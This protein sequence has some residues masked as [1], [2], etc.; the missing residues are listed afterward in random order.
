MLS[1]VI[2]GSGYRAEYF[3]R[4][5]AAYPSLFRAMYLCRSEEKAALMTAHTG[6]P[7]STSRKEC[8]AFQ[9][10]FA[11]IAVDR[12]H[13]AEVAEEWIRDGYPVVTETPVGD[14]F[15][16]LERLWALSRE[17]AKIVCC[18]Q[19]HRYPIL[20][21]GLNAV[22]EGKIGRPASLYLSLAH[23]YH[24]ASLIRRL[25][26]VEGGEAYT[27]R[28][29]RQTTPVI[30]SDSRYGAILDG[31]A[32]PDERTIL[33]ISF[34]SGK[35][36]IYDF[37][38]VEYRSFLR[39]RHL[40]VRGERGEWSDCIVYRLDGENRPRRD[41]LMPEIPGRYA[42]LDT[43]YLR[44]LRKTWHSELFLDTQQDE[45]AVASLLFDMADYLA[46]GPSPYPLPEAMDD[47]AF[48][49]MAEEAVREPWKE[50]R[51]DKLPWHGAGI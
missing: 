9:P 43:Q 4:I 34:A 14:T 32:G 31:S 28:G 33:H 8:L 29:M 23:D 27:L 15:E 26:L 1:Y 5:A 35:T 38:P 18:E 39:S 30:S 41:F 42:A 10:D 17:G 48:W 51:V 49:L 19:Y 47:A 3:G 36:A 20:M 50:I 11:V 16:K 6:A 45:F 13:V 37:A 12:G 24:A 25:L 2:V 44:D 21:A 46:G 7:A 40:T 22:R